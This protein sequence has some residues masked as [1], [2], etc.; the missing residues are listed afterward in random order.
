MLCCNVEPYVGLGE[1]SHGPI[2]YKCSYKMRLISKNLACPICKVESKVLIIATE[3]KEFGTFN[4]EK[5]LS[6]RSY[7][8]FMFESKHSMELF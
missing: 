1:C 5:M 4:L 6:H 2:C 8:G 7:P 3:P